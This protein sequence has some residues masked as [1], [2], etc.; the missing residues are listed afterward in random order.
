[1]VQTCQKCANESPT[2]DK[3]CRQ[4][5][6]PFVAE[7]A[8]SGAATRNYIKQERP[9]SVATGDSGYFPPSVADAIVGETERYY[10]PPQV[11]VPPPQS[12]SQFRAKKS[13]RWRGFLWVL[14]FLL[15]ALIGSM[16]TIP[17]VRFGRTARPATP[18][19]SIRNDAEREARRR[20]ERRRRE[21]LDKMREAKERSDNAMERSRQAVQ[22]F[23]EA[24]DRAREAGP[25]ILNIGEKLLDLSEYEYTATNGNPVSRIANRIPGY[26]MLTI[27]TSDDF[28]TIKQFYQKKIGAPIIEIN[29]PYEKWILFQTEKS[30]SMIVYVDSEFPDERRIV[31][32]R[33]P[34]RIVPIED[35][36][37]KK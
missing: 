24:L 33:Y 17:L 12:T 30:P 19:Q 25:I 32:L 22:R 37:T 1:M 4:C 31:V 10:Q 9:P 36:Q 34:F 18:E 20:E 3:F 27:R 15:S 6:E 14:A 5:G 29:E 2:G 35:T 23:R 21:V 26:E 16:I 8:T 28:E 11:P 7:S 13:W